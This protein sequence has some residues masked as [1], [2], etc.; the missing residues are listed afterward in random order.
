MRRPPPS[1]LVLVTALVGLASFACDEPS[2]SPPPTTTPPPSEAPSE[3]EPVEDEPAKPA[4]PAEPAEPP[5]PVGGPHCDEIELRQQCI[6][7]GE[8]RGD[9]P[10]CIGE[11]ELAE[12]P[13]PSE[14]V[15][16]SCQLPTTGVIIRYY[17]DAE[18]ARATCK[19]I[20]GV[21]TPQK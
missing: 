19:T 21:F 6:D 15:V 10:R 3:D 17:A 1:V 7:Y 12:G 9:P 2:T 14:G 13:C 18:A 4:E 8:H 5:P 16:A 20:Y 11:V